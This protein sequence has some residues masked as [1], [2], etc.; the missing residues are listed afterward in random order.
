MFFNGNF[1]HSGL[2]FYYY[3]YVLFSSSSVCRLLSKGETCLQTACLGSWFVSCFLCMESMG[4]SLG[5]K[6]QRTKRHLSNVSPSSARTQAESLQ[7]CC[8]WS[9]SLYSIAGEKL[10]FIWHQLA[11]LWWICLLKQHITKTEYIH[12]MVYERKQHSR[13]ST[14]YL[15]INIL[16]VQLRVFDVLIS[17][18]LACSEG[19]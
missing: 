13:N 12:S 19:L 18:T 5:D 6:K 11:S 9:F 8:L 17:G 10:P 4:D 15:D 1:V 16:P 3:S 7:M 2:F 14:A